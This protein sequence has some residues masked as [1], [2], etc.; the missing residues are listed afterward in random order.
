[1]GESLSLSTIVVVLIVC[2]GLFFGIRRIVAGIA[3]GKSCCSDGETVR[4]VKHVEVTDTDPANYPFDTTLLIGGMSCLGCAD[5]V[6]N[7][8]NGVPGT[9]ATVDLASKE[10]HVRSKNAIDAAAYEAAVKDA[11]Y[12]VMKL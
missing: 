9:W 8:L 11:G 3:S 1:M 5:N 6:A 4:H 2:I 10:A 12:Y 7:A